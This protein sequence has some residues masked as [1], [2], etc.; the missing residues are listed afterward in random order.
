MAICPAQ[1]VGDRIDHTGDFVEPSEVDLDRCSEVD[2]LMRLHGWTFDDACELCCLDPSCYVAGAPSL[3]HLPTPTQIECIAGE[4]RNGFAESFP[5]YDAGAW[6]R[7]LALLDGD[8]VYPAWF[9][10]PGEG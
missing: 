8:V 1:A 9:T 2:A 10:M 3:D 5:A 7:Y 6:E 4:L